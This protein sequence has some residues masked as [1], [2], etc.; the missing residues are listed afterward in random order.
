MTEKVSTPWSGGAMAGLV[1]GT[2]IIPLVGIIAGI[3]GMNKPA[4]KDQGLILLVL[5]IAM[6]AIY[7]CM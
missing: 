6:I 7:A 3:V 5:G 1:I 2:V 4:K